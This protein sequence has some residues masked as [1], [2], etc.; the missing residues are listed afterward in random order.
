MS[1]LPIPDGAVAAVVA[2][3]DDETFG[4]GALL[5]NLAGEN[6]AVRVLCFT[7]G[8]A[9]TLGI[10]DG[11]GD[12]RRSELFEA[13][14][15]LGVSEIT[16]LDFADGALDAV[17]DTELD[18]R[19]DRWLT[20]DVAALVVFEPQGVT[21][22]PDHQAATKA[23]ERVADHRALP[24]I[25]WGIDPDT[26][27][28]MNADHGLSLKS[29]VDGPDVHDLRVD[30]TAQLAAIR[31]HASQRDD[32]PIVCQVLALQGDIE[33]VRLRTPRNSNSAL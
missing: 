6:R 1:M 10:S 31:K 22:H 7:R 23:A 28:R 27:S 13:A 21:G 5:A 4:L 15:I 8:E 16:L 20:P 3:P 24:V 32:H 19:I 2:H 9:S 25:E 17:P 18:D 30:R 11:L 33:R 12:I 26:A 14:A 29:I